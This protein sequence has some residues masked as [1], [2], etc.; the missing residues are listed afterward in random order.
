MQRR[1]AGKSRGALVPLAYNAV[2]RRTVV[3]IVWISV[4]IASAAIAAQLRAQDSVAPTAREAALA[5]VLT[6]NVLPIP[7]TNVAI[8]VEPDFAM[9]PS[10]LP[11]GRGRPPTTRSAE[12]VAL[13]AAAL[14]ARVGPDA[15]TAPGRE[16][17]V[18]VRYDCATRTAASVVQV[19]DPAPESAGVEGILIV[20]FSPGAN[21]SER[22]LWSAVIQVEKR[23]S[24]WIATR[25]RLSSERPARVRVPVDSS[26]VSR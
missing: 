23:D 16:V 21:R 2:T 18:C 14:A 9:R 5:W 11:P 25:T 1:G 17:L 22:V 15:R 4:M 12:V 6:H 24:G 7:R 19:R 10:D 8:V 26:G 13:E 3:F 20:L